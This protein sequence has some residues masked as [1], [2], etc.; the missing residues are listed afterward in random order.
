MLV[1][2][3]VGVCVL[4]SVGGGVFI[5]DDRSEEARLRYM[6]GCVPV[7]A[8]FTAYQNGYRRV[9]PPYRKKDVTAARK[10]CQ[11]KWSNRRTFE[12]LRTGTQG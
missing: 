6:S 11:D 1:R 10:I 7:L 3:V 9:D 5:F 4:G 8:Q 12:F 2:G